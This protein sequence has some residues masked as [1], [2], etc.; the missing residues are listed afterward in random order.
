M[1]RQLT[2]RARGAAAAVAAFTPAQKVLAVLALALLVLGGTAFSRWV[3]TPTYTPLFANL[4]AEDA[5][6]ITELLTASGTQYQLEDG[7][8]TIMVPRE[9][10]NAQR[11]AAASAGLP[12]D[13]ETGYNLLDTA[14]VTSSQF[15][16]QITYQRAVEGELA[17]TIESIEGVRTAVV[18]LAIPEETVFTDEAVPPTASV[19]VDPRPGASLSADQVQSIVHLVSSSVPELDADQ[20]TVAD[21]DGTLLAAPGQ[22][23]GI[24]GAG[25][26]E[27]A[28]T[29]YERRTASAVQAMLDKVVGPGRAVATVTAELDFDQTQRTSEA[30]TYEDGVP[31]LSETTNTEEYTGTGGVGVGGA[32][33]ANGVL[34]MDGQEVGAAGTGDSGYTKGSSTRNNAVNKTT[35]QVTEAPGTVRRQS[36]A[37]VVDTQ[38]AAAAGVPELTQ[39][40]TAAAGVQADRGDTL[41]VSQVPFDTSTTDAAAEELA[42]AREAEAAQAR[43][44]LIAQAAAGALVLLL[45]LVGLVLWRRAVRRRKR[46]VVDLGE[47]EAIYR[48]DDVVTQD[49]EALTPG[50][51]LALPGSEVLGSQ[52][53]AVGP[54]A[55]ALRRA[56]V[57]D[58]VDA[59]PTEVA[60]VLRGWLSEKAR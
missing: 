44:T 38:A 49:G 25:G 4:A 59:Q 14:G 58:L 55:A 36:I 10:V 11:L 53:A 6:A 34:G 7:G 48:R 15:Q 29:E 54:S 22:G 35:E 17:A 20:V 27:G 37:V 26:R 46:Q 31:P 39:M 24:G 60:E 40:V 19:L 45:L 18:H 32:L 1:P 3:A 16:Q 41:A 42:A 12:S 51:A 50:A 8:T 28:T 57:G 43:N 56:E 30:F 33:G 2:A 21:A 47:L 13:T 5:S 23:I 52:L 9:A